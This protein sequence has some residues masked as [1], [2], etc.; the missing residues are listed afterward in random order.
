MTSPLV[1]TRARITRARIPS[2][3][4]S[5]DLAE[6]GLSL[7]VSGGTSVSIRNEEDDAV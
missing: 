2:W 7:N 6:Q 1:E 5:A 4:S 3:A